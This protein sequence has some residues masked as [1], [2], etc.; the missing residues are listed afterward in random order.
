MIILKFCV[1]CNDS[2]YVTCH[3]YWQCLCN[4]FWNRDFLEK[5]SN[6]NF[7][8][9]RENIQFPFNEWTQENFSLEII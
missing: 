9:F 3:V 1:M 8:T 6:E 7:K 4:I 2:F 5:N